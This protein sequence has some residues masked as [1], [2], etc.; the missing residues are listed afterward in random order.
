MVASQ[1]VAAETAFP[2]NLRRAVDAAC[3]GAPDDP[4]RF[5]TLGAIRIIAHS[6][7]DMGGRPGRAETT[8]ILDDAQNLTVSALF[9]GGRLRR[10]ALELS[11]TAP[12]ASIAVDDACRVTEARRIDYDNDGRA[13]RIRVFASDLSTETMSIDLNPPIPSGQDPGGVRVGVIDSGVNYRLTEIAPH[14][15]RDD[16]GKLLG[17]DLWDGDD[18]PFDIDTG[19]SAFF[20]L[21]HGTSVTSVLVREAPMA[22]VLPI[23][24]P[25]PDMTKMKD[26]VSWL[27]AQ[28]V[29][30]VNMAMGSNSAD[31]WQAFEAAA[32]AHPQM[33][34]IVS[35]GNDGRDIDRQPVYPAALGLPNTVVV[36]SSEPDGRLARGSNWGAAH[37]DLLVPG[38]R[39]PVTD[40]RGAPGK[41]SGSS[42]AVPRVTALAVRMKNAHPDWRGPELRDA[43]LKR[44]RPLAGR[45]LSRYGWLPDPTDGP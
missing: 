6:L 36:T 27:S 1:A 39:I 43:I 22:S 44:G 34:F 7:T 25:R 10:I 11:D 33:L 18:R 3:A 26:A 2:E 42:Y 23:R 15:A 13:E 14:L 19:R 32:R 37:V 29:T 40:H 38:E 28:G 20:P 5:R 12:R 8:F 16:S 4:Q 31:E 17:I 9:P 41:A 21:H 45:K 24:Y 30:I 35:A